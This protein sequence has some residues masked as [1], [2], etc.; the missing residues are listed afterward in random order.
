ML[1]VLVSCDTILSAVVE[2]SGVP[3]FVFDA[4]ALSGVPLLG[5]G[6]TTVSCGGVT[7]RGEENDGITLRAFSSISTHSSISTLFACR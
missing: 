6:L 4:G 1:D 3:V 7:G 5:E 2:C